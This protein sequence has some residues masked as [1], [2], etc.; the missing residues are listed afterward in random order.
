MNG[1]QMLNFIVHSS[2]SAPLSPQGGMMW[3]DSTNKALKHYNDSSLSWVSSIAGP[4]ST[5]S[6]NIPQWSGTSGGSLSTGLSLQT[7]LRA[8]ASASD[9]ALV[10]EKA[11]RT[12]IDLISGGTGV[13]VH[14][15]LTGLDADD[16]TQYLT[17]ARGDARYS[18]LGHTHAFE[19]SLGNPSVDG[20]IL[21]SNTSG[22]RSWIAPPSGGG[23]IYPAAGI[24]LSTGS[25][26]GTSITN[27]S[28]NWNT[29][30]G[31]GNHASAGYL[32]SINKAQVEAVLT[33]SISSHTHATLVTAGYSI[34][35]EGG[36]LKIKYGSTVILT[37]SS[38]GFL[39]AKDDI[40]AFE[41]IS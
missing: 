39:K 24:A 26:W 31:W 19:A 4:A 13:T 23:M 17:T 16:H 2:A 36:I 9:S 5:T 35:E 6:G 8:A 18:Q 41:T 40:G 7:T 20:Y 29:A 22:V 21:S 33:G 28:A 11:I 12:A 37:L 3:W 14:N 10:T 25:S 38:A 1:N 15:Q 34:V 30:Y 27:N 32:T